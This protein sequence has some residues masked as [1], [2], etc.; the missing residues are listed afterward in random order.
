MIHEDSEGQWLWAEP[1][2]DPLTEPSWE[3][4]EIRS[5]TPE[6]PSPTPPTTPKKTKKVWCKK[7][8]TSSTNSPSMDVSHPKI[9]I[10]GCEILFECIYPS[11]DYS[12]NFPDFSGN[13]SHFLQS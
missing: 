3:D 2:H 10:L 12:E 9:S 6:D 8:P 1:D 11:S 7:T 4:R 13:C 5:L